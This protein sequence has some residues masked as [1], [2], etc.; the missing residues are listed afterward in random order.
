[1]F[2]KPLMLKKSSALDPHGTRRVVAREVRKGKF[3]HYIHSLFAGRGG[4]RNLERKH[5]DPFQNVG[6]AMF[7]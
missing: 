3:A 6:I 7:R 2:S 5:T 4:K 1:M